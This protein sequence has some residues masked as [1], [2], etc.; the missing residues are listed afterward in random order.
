MQRGEV[1]AAVEFLAVVRRLVA[2]RAD[3]GVC[4]YPGPRSGSTRFEG[5]E[6]DL[7]W[8]ADVPLIPPSLMV[9]APLSTT[10]VVLLF[11]GIGG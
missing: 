2:L 5:Y 6:T 8:L 7:G 9:A 10:M 11:G 1:G 4:Y 3:D